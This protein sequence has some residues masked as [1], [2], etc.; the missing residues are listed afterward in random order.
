MCQKKVIF[1][2]DNNRLFAEC[3]YRLKHVYN[4][5]RHNGYQNKKHAV[6]KTGVYPK[7]EL[8][9]SAEDSEVPD[10]CL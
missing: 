5:V 6:L 8:L 4:D 1:H 2:V 3:A 9:A 10:D 7:Y